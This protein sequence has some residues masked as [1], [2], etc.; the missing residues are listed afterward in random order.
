VNNALYL[1][2]MLIALT[3]M[4][5]AAWLATLYGPSGTA[6]LVGMAGA[7]LMAFVAISAMVEPVPY[8]T[9][10]PAELGEENQS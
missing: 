6:D 5:F 7:G 2:T 8:V 3:L 10:D 4:S 9:R 1:I